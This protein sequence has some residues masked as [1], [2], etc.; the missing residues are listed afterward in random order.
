LFP[1]AL[2]DISL[3]IIGLHPVFWLELIT[4]KRPVGCADW[5]KAIRL[6]L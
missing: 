1:E 2:A 3:F 4:V 5:L 6:L